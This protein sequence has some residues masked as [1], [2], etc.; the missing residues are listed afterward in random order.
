MIVF[1]TLLYAGIIGLLAKL[2]IIKWSAGWGLSIVGWAT[3]LLVVLFIPMQ[4][5]AP[6]GAVNV[7]QD[8]VEV[9]PNVGGEVVSIEAEGMKLVKKGDPLFRIDPQPYQL[10][11]DGLRAQLEDA[12][13][14]VGRLNAKLEAANATVAKTEADIELAKAEQEVALSR[15]DSASAALKEARGKKE[16]AESV[17]ADLKTQVEAAERE[18]DRL[19]TLNESNNVSESEVDRAKI[20]VTGLESQL[21]SAEVDVR[22]SE[23]TIHRFEADVATAETGARAADLRVK[24]LVETELPRVKANAKEAEL[25]A[26]SMIGNEHTTVAA[27]RAQLESAEYNLEETVVRAP[28]DGQVIGL[29]LAVGQRVTNMPMRAAMTFVPTGGLK[30]GVGIPQYALRHVEAGQ[31]VEITFKLYPGQVFGATVQEVAPMN[32]QGQQQPTGVVMSTPG[33]G[34]SAT[35][36]GVRLKLNDEDLYEA[37]P[38]GAIGTA[39]IYTSKVQMAHVIR[40]VMLRMDAW[41]NYIRPW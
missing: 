22:V 30:V 36:F 17:V 26:N 13:Q 12:I 39:A 24:Q 1:L 33:L 18:L 16:K 32:A 25:A 29:T 10:V 34:Q 6:S 41:L 37:L 40:R 20:Q 23:D 9:V 15:I 31:E 8:V 5:G 7:Y 4:W 28:S 19:V 21:N 27:V 38:G 14:N 11:V 35:P 2:K 3:L